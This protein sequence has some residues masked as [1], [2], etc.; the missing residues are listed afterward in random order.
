MFCLLS[1]CN[2]F[3][4]H[5]QWKIELKNNRDEKDETTF[6]VFVLTGI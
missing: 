2:L 1:I 4:V 6:K 3:L 5:G